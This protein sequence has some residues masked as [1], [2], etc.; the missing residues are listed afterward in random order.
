[1]PSEI[2]IIE[3]CLRM[4]PA[5]P[6][7]ACFDTGFHH[8]LP[9][10]ARVLPLPRRFEAMGVRRYGFHGLSY[11]YLIGELERLAGDASRGRVI[12]AHLG[13]GASMAAVLGGRPIDTTMAFTP[14][15]GLVMATRSGDID[16]GLVDFLAQQT[17]MTT[18]EFHAMT[19]H[20]SGLLGVSTISGDMRELLERESSDPR[21]RLAVDLF[22][23][24]ARM[25]L[26]GLAA[27][28]GGL[29]LLVFSAGVGERSAPVRER[30]C[31]GLDFLGIH[32][33][34]DRN[35]RHEQIIS[36]DDSPTA[37]WVV[38]TD[39]ELVIAQAA[40]RLLGPP[41]HQ[42]SATPPA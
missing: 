37:V 22:C 3:A 28:L 20:E 18:A 36:T 19:S 24:R 11:T 15:A 38:P 17:G 42:E 8:D 7:V 35:R 12:L 2:A 1:L 34:P 29:D 14:A 33:D 9:E 39:E 10:V 25:A 27:A 32:L 31:Q 6:Q 30:I 41:A 16:P 40:C 4:D 23:Y 5:R 26:G 13:A 21:A